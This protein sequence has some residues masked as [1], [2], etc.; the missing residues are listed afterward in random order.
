MA[1]LQAQ[2]QQ[3][4]NQMTAEKGGKPVV[5]AGGGGGP[6]APVAPR[7]PQCHMLDGTKVSACSPG[8]SLCTCD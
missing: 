2:N 8:D 1:Q 6:A 4:Q 3:L 5:K 7:K